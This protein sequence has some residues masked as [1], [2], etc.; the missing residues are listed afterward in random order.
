MPHVLQAAALSRL[1][2]DE[3]ARIVVR[4]L[5]ELQPGI[6]AAAAVL[7]ARYVNPESMAALRSALLRAGLPEHA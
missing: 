4:R 6:N 7:S 5:L 3:D 2:R 1:D